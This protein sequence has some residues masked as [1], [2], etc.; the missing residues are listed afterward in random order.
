[1]M[2]RTGSVLV[3]H[4]LFFFSGPF[5]LKAFFHHKEHKVEDAENTKKLKLRHYLRTKKLYNE[6]IVLVFSSQI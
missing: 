5:V 2:L 3:C 4:L 1:M 6:V